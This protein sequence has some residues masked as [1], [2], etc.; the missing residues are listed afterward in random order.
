MD[1]E[2]KGESRANDEVA[3]AIGSES[4]TDGISCES[5]HITVAQCL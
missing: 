3:A 2:I 4:I 5:I 1:T